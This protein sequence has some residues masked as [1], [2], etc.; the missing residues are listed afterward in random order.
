MLFKKFLD[1]LF[2]KHIH[3]FKRIEFIYSDYSSYEYSQNES[4]I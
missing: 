2:V 4:I 1:K 3:R